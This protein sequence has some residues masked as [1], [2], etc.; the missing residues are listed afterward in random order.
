M[1]S[2]ELS[3]P[4]GA[5]KIGGR[6]NL[7]EGDVAIALGEGPSELIDGLTSPYFLDT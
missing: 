1:R 6:L 3:S 2:G 4:L 7:P 5:A